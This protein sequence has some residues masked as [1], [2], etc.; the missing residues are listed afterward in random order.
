[1]KNGQFYSGKKTKNIKA[2]FF[3]IKDRVD[4]RDMQEIDCPT[5]EM[6]ADVLTKTFAGY[7]IQEDESS[8]DELRHRVQRERD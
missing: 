7:G 2:K 8:I 3:Y 4:G 5:E 6:W 1:M